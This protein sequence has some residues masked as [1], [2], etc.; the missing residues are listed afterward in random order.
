[1]ARDMDEALR[2]LC[3]LSI[4]WGD[5]KAEWSTTQKRVPD[6]KLSVSGVEVQRRPPERGIVMLGS[7]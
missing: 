5:D 7:Q 3:G 4:D 1:M 2:R 6:F